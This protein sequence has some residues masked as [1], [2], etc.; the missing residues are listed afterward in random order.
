MGALP[1]EARALLAH[2]FPELATDPHLRRTARV[3]EAITPRPISGDELADLPDWQLWALTHAHRITRAR[4]RSGAAIPF[5]VQQLAA[6]ALYGT[7]PAGVGDWSGFRLDRGGLWVD[8]EARPFQPDELRPARVWRLH[9]DEWQRLANQV[10][11][12]SAS[13]CVPVFSPGLAGGGMC[14]SR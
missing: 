2:F 14:L 9:F 3:R 4:W 13:S 6:L 11:R 5:P 8:G 7:I 1:T 12:D 10:R